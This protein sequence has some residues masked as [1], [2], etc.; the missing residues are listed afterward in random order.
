MF[1]R[2][3]D[4]EERLEVLEERIETLK[5]KND[6]VFC[7]KCGVALKKYKAQEVESDAY[8][9]RESLLAN[10]GFGFIGREIV[11]YCDRHKKNYDKEKIFYSG[12]VIVK[13]EYFKINVEV[14]QKGENI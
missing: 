12:G 8:K 4:L 14:N 11:Y 9:E 5:E 3:K 13:E 6:I 10:T 2:T 1:K 7:N